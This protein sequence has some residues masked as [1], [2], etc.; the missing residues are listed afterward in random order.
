MAHPD[1]DK[2]LQPECGNSNP[3][4]M[5]SVVVLPQPKARGRH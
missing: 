1:D 3:A 2:N 5:R 4:I